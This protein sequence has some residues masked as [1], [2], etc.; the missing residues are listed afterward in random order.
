MCQFLESSQGCWAVWDP[1]A[2]PDVWYAEMCQFHESSQGCW[3]VWD[4]PATPDV[5]VMWDVSTAW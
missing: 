5:C 2:T 4:P 3:A 1:P